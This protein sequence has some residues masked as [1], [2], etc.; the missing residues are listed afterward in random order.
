MHA[1]FPLFALILMSA[2]SVAADFR[3]GVFWTKDNRS[4]IEFY[5]HNLYD[6]AGKL[7]DTKIKCKSKSVLFTAEREHGTFEAD[8]LESDVQNIFDEAGNLL[9]EY[10][11][12]HEELIAELCTSEMVGASSP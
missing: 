7:D 9:A 12:Q 4:R 1:P 5:C 3:S 8:W 6:D 2:T 11:V 10:Q